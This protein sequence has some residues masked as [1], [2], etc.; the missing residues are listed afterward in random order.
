M[1]RENDIMRDWID[2]KIDSNQALLK[3]APL[4]QRLSLWA[5]R[6]YNVPGHAEDIEQELALALLGEAAKKWNPVLSI[7]SYMT[8]WAWRIA[9]SISQSKMREENFDDL[10]SK[11]ESDM[12]CDRTLEAINAIQDD[13]SIYAMIDRE[14]L[15]RVPDGFSIDGLERALSEFP[16]PDRK[17]TSDRIKKARRLKPNKYLL[18]IRHA[19]GMTRADMAASMGI[20]LG[21]YAGYES[22]KIQSVPEDIYERANLVYSNMG[23]RTRLTDEIADLPMSEII[24]KWCRM[25]NCSETEAAEHLGISKRTLRRWIEDDYKPR[26]SIVLRHHIKV[27]SLS[28]AR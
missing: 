19:V 18:K 7:S 4:L 9:S 24:Q 16:D 10:Y 23:H 6:K 1:C 3:L 17:P 12:L 20:S 15:R 27:E 5:A 21:R 11:T 26:H 8:G 2:G 22:G 13:Q 28:H 14:F 25:L